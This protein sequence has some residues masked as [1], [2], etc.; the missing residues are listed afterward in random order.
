MNDADRHILTIF[1]EA[2]DAPSLEAQAAYLDKACGGDAALRERVEALLLSH[3][4]AGGFLPAETSA[5]EHRRPMPGN[6]PACRE[7]P[8]SVI[9]PYKLLQQIGE[10]G[11]GIVYM[12]EQTEP[13]R[14]MVALKIIKAGMDSRQ[15]IAR[16]EAERQA[17]ALMDHPNIARVL[18]A[19]T[20]ENG[21]PYFV[22]ELVK[23]VPITKYCD[24]RRLTPKQRLELFLPVCHAVQ[25]A[26]QKAIIHRDLKPSNVL[27]A[28]YDD[29]PV[30]KVIDFGIAKATGS[31]LTERTM[32]TELGQ[33]VGTLE[34]MSP[35]QAKLNA[36]DIDT[37]SDIYSLGVL[38]YELL[39]GT[40]P[41]EKKRLQQAA[42][43]EI[44]RFIREEEPPRPSTRLSATDELPSVAANR[45]TEPKRL[46]TLVRGELDWIVMKALEKDR[47]RRYETPNSFALDIQRYLTDE[48]VQACPPSAWYRV[49]KFARRSKGRLVVGACVV[50][51]VTVM[52]ASIGW[53]V[54][55][56]A[57]RA[58]EVER[59]EIVRRAGVA[60]QVRDSLNAVRLLIA[61]NKLSAA[62]QKLAEAK[63][64]LG[65]D[66]PALADLAAEVEAGETELSRYQ[67]F[68]DSIDRAHRA[69][70][71]PRPE[72]ILL[73][74]ATGA[75]ADR[76]PRLTG[77]ERRPAAAV[78][79]LL[80]ALQLYRIL[81][82]DD[83]D[84]GFDGGLLGKEQM[85]HIRGA[86]YEELLWLADDLL[87]RQQEHRTGQKLSPEAAARK[88]LEYLGKAEDVH[89]PTQALFVLRS[90]C[91]NALGEEAASR[92]DSKL[93]DQTPPT[94]ASDY[95]LL[96][97]AALDRDDKSAAVK[98]FQAAL[99]LQP[100][101]YESLMRLGISQ[102]DHAAATAVFTGC[103][104]KRPEHAHAYYCRAT[105]YHFRGLEKDAIADL[106]RAIKL[107][108]D[109]A[110]A[111]NNR[112]S[113]Y[114]ALGDLDKALADL[115][116]A[117]KLAPNWALP[118]RNR[119]YVH[120][121]LQQPAQAI[122]DYSRAIELDENDVF[123]WN[124]RAAVYLDLGQ[125]ARTVADAS[126]AIKLDKKCA[127]AWSGRGTA[128]LGLGQ[129]NEAL[130]DLSMAIRLDGKCH[131][132]LVNRGNVYL[133]LKQPEKALADLNEAVA[134]DPKDKFA[135]ANR[136]YAYLLL[137]QP[138]KV[139]DDCTEAIKLDQNYA[140]AWLNRGQA[141]LR[142]NQLDEAQADMS[143]GLKL[144]DRNATAWDALGQL[145][146]KLGQRDNAV[147][148]F[149]KAVELDP[150][151]PRRWSNRGNAHFVF[152][153]LE[154]AVTDLSR[155][156]TMAGNKP[157]VTFMYLTRGRCYYL[158]AHYPQAVSDYE[159]VVKLV[160]R[161][162][163]AHNDLAWLLATRPEP[164]LRE[165]GRAVELAKKAIQLAPGDA[166]FW[167]TLG[168]A[169]YRAADW[170]DALVALDKSE[171]LQKGGKGGDAG[172]SL[173]L[174]MT[175]RQLGNGNEARQHYDQAIRWVEN[176]KEA[177]AKDKPLA[178]EIRRFQHEAEEVLELKKK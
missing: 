46:T 56:H 143:Q 155:A 64:Q 76:I 1:G 53:A 171:K 126:E 8:G 141:H 42:F 71:A 24:E 170:K 33:V 168:V 55:D 78:P 129:L 104:M 110:Y 74:D 106:S 85:G 83:W 94:V 100:T 60:G 152:G 157:D 130:E 2:L 149:S 11:M 153:Q 81:E 124:D 111:W 36:L 82:R 32:F 145:F 114:R 73:T 21:R 51:A 148:H 44:L 49:G 14:R 68:L 23:G 86:A 89:E 13:V 158:L 108:P 93:A 177:L 72:S 22:M 66:G 150:N 87:Q 63:A 20:T 95:Y 58:A 4:E 163:L 31:K 54:R 161:H 17:L 116:M 154:D 47:N 52:A 65:S 88:A 156:I 103:I 96:G 121:R 27:V 167:R 133:K 61:D 107:A 139:I 120:H 97:Q 174:A 162:A 7:G 140:A 41:F 117:I 128:H 75:S 62:R 176:N 137:G 115:N 19:D 38:L 169:R 15:V 43:D 164:K 79:F 12:A 105:S 131:D 172:A 10:G 5:F 175:H 80:Q 40:T 3:R 84:T 99:L 30:A 132:A 160:P 135:W 35:E 34:Y 166:H 134:G 37:R 69:E 178:D 118:F 147:T 142:L 112:G 39:T 25:H 92:A 45:G 144:N 29:R 50:L 9:G 113:S 102:A 165:P 125:F 28:E 119:G 159:M 101:H 151:N 16:F 18:D 77:W 59:S 70:T 91:R 57:A 123:A 127:L 48:P 173:F 26:H 136:G 90:R 109:H 138:D 122:A 67:Q 146:V 6:E 98:A